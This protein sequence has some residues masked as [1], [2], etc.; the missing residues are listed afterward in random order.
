[1]KNS[2]QN[3]PEQPKTENQKTSKKINKASNRKQR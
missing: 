3:K 2:K 1:M